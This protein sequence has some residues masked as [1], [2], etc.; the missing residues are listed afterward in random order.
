MKMMNRLSYCIRYSWRIAPV[1]T[2]T[3]PIAYVV[4]S[5]ISTFLLSKMLIS[6]V[7]I[8]ISPPKLAPITIT[9]SKSFQSY[10]IYSS[11]VSFLDS[12]P[13]NASSTSFPAC[14]YKKLVRVNEVKEIELEEKKNTLLDQLFM[15]KKRHSKLTLQQ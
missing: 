14:I 10:Y 5:W 9:I 1:L 4:H 12:W 8:V 3:A 15:K 7:I 13:S 6:V 2:S 11:L